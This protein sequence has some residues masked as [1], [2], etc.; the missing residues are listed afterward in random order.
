MADRG[1]ILIDISIDKWGEAIKDE[2]WREASV[3]AYR[4]ASAK[5]YTEVE[6]DAIRKEYLDALS[7][8]ATFGNNKLPDY[9]NP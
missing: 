7:A 1:I 4:N 6:K 5:V 3:K 8:Y 9:Q 2:K